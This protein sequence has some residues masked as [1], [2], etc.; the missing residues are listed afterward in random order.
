MRMTAYGRYSTAWTASSY[1][2]SD[3]SWGPRS[4]AGHA[5]MYMNA[6]I[7]YASRCIKVICT[8]STEAETIAGVAATKD[9][10]F[11]RSI[12]AFLWRAVTSPTPLLIDNSGMWFNVRNDV[13]SKNNRHWEIWELY[14]RE[15]YLTLLISI[16][17]V[18]GEEERADI[19]TKPLPKEDSRY[20]RFR[21]DL[22]N[23]SLD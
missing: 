22:L 4:Q 23:F 2:W 17:K 14:V 3:A 11:A 20:L 7:A 8:S 18:H 16:H 6:T 5:V 1:V 12:L 19:L 21:N 15:G 10:K 13:L 9:V